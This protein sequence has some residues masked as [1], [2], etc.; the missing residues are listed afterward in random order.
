MKFK[1]SNENFLKEAHD[2]FPHIEVLGEYTGSRDIMTFRCKKHNVVFQK[3]ATNFIHSK[4][5]CDICSK[6]G[7]KDGLRKSQEWFSNELKLKNPNVKQIG[8][9]SGMNSKVKVKCVH[10]GKIYESRANDLLLGHYCRECAINDFGMSIRKDQNWFLDRAKKYNKNYNNIEFLS[11]Y[12]GT[13]RNVKCHCKVCENEWETKASN[14]IDKRGGTGCPICNQS[15]GEL[16]IRDYLINKG[17]DFEQQK[18]FNGLVG[19]YGF[20]LLFDFYLPNFNMLIEINGEQHYTPI[21]YF[22]GTEKFDK[23]REHDNKKRKFVKDNGFKLLEIEYK[24][25]ADISKMVNI[26]QTNL[27][28]T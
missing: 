19:T 10:C 18:S 26:L 17:I 15:Q 27:L 11:E 5:G 12:E 16:A 22:G 3:T 24:N 14:L 20:P 1:K 23:Q 25:R 8:Q 9:Y 7:R 4:W 21:K 13:G 28:N 6:E 2:K